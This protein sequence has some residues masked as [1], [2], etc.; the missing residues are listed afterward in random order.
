M[1]RRLARAAA[2]TGAAFLLV[3]GWAA[4]PAAAD[5]A[6]AEFFE[7]RG[8]QASR[9]KRWEDALGHYRRALQEDE[10]YLPA[11]WGLGEALVGAGQR[12]PGIEEM[13]RF[14]LEAG[15]AASLPPAWAA[16]LARARK[17]L[18]EIDALGTELTRLTE[19]SVG[20]LLALA[21]RWMEKDP[22][23]AKRALLHVLAL[24]PGHAEATQL[25][26]TLGAPPPDA[27]VVEVFNR[28]DTDGWL[29]MGPPTF[30]VEDQLLVA[31]TKGKAVIA[32]TKRD[33]GG[34]VDVGIELRVM[35]TFPDP[36]YVGLGLMKGEYDL[37]EL[38]MF[39]D[40]LI[41]C[42]QLTEEDD[43]NR[44]FSKDFAAF[45]PPVDLRAWNRFELRLRKGRVGVVVN[46]KQVDEVD[47]P[48]RRDRGFVSLKVQES[49][50]Q[51]R[52]VTVA[53]R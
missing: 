29:W 42:D 34:D 2:S 28:K 51:V 7:Q 49:L 32:R 37:L 35:E 53:E 8:N 21:K 52:S 20:P 46:G 47:R 44:M 36:M 26:S 1:R 45:D 5:R 3:L 13:R 43:T 40:K 39:E 16:L 38:G 33:Y 9:E 14:V 4:A 12:A 22:D 15:S 31:R 30:A 27:K 50:V 10:T 6:T 23:V 18:G 19:A 17:R 24:R 11:R 41:V 48:E 25:L